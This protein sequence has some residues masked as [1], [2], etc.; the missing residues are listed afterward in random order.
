SGVVEHVGTSDGNSSLVA[1]FR[2]FRLNFIASQLDLL[3]DGG[4]LMVCG[5]NRLFPFDFQH[6]DHY[7]GP[8]RFFDR[9]PVARHMTLPWHPKN[10]LVSYK[11]LKGLAMQCARDLTFIY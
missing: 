1:N 11:D 10:H 9:F 2:D 7:Y 5:P 6:G 8:L 4:I 3:R